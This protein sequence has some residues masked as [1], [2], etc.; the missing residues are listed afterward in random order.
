MNKA[1]SNKQTSISSQNYAQQN[2][3]NKT[4][5]D[6]LRKPMKQTS[7]IF[8]KKKKKGKGRPSQKSQKAIHYKKQKF[9]I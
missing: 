9:Q 1:Y 4:R 2:R 6:K 5:Y 7:F 3:V 8:K